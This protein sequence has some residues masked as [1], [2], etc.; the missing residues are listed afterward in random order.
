MREPTYRRLYC[1]LPW[2]GL[3]YDGVT[4]SRTSVRL[5]IEIASMPSRFDP[6]VAITI[7]V[8]GQRR[9]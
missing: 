9:R 4:F 1:I 7:P 6:D 3:V 8:N 5:H 2:S